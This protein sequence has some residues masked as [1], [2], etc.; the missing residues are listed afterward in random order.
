MLVQRSRSMDPSFQSCLVD[1]LLESDI[2]A[3]DQFKVKSQ[4]DQ[5]PVKKAPGRPPKAVDKNSNG[6]PCKGRLD[7][8]W[9]PTVSL[10]TDQ[11]KLVRYFHFVWST[12]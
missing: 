8:N 6:F 4:V 10:G 1:L 7:T 9:S 11:P 3:L 2:A 12:D 5:F